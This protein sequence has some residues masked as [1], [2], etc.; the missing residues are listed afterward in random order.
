LFQPNGDWGW[1]AFAGIDARV[2][3]RDIFLDGNTW[4]DSRSVDKETLVSDASLGLALIMPR[5][6]LTATYTL[7]SKEFTTQRDPAQSGPISLSFRF[8]TETACDRR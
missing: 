8:W 6:W 2:V 3:G 7:R 5:A 1:Y 4:R